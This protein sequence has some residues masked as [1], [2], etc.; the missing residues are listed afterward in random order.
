MRAWIVAS[1]LAL[2]PAVFAQSDP[3]NRAGQFPQFRD[4]SGLPGG[5]FGVTPEGLPSI[6]GALAL[7]TP[8]G[9]SLGNGIFDIAFASRSYDNSPQFINTGTAGRRRSDGTGQGL[10]G[11]QTPLGLF[12]AGYELISSKLDQTYNAQLQLP[13][14]WKKA[15]ISLGCQNVTNR[16]EAAGDHVAGEDGMSRSFY[17]AGTYEVADGDYLTLGVGNVRFKGV[18]GSACAMITPQVKGMLEY[19]TISWN[20][21]VAWSLG[22]LGDFQNTET[23]LFF[24][25]VGMHRATVSVSFAF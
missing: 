17:A 12:T 3:I 8:I 22:R 23:T 21:G 13:L 16:P 7:S 18:F 5:G 4:L 1:L 10:I 25:Y 2:A 11:V 9:F 14:A 19:D 24:G 15:G 20:T 6:R